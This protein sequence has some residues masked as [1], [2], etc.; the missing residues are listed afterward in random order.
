MSRQEESARAW[1]PYITC[2]ALGTEM[3]A[4]GREGVRAGWSKPSG[5]R[6]AFVPEQRVGRSNRVQAA[7]L[8]GRPDPL[9]HEAA[10]ATSESGFQIQCL[11]APGPAG[12]EKG[13]CSLASRFERCFCPDSSQVL[14]GCPYPSPWQLLDARGALEGRFR[15]VLSTPPEHPRSASDCKSTKTYLLLG[16]TRV[17]SAGLPALHLAEDGFGNSVPQPCFQWHP[18]GQ[19][20]GD[21]SSGLH[22]VSSR[23]PAGEAFVWPFRPAQRWVMLLCTV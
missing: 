18:V 23:W 21:P 15:P 17:S 2:T 5:L 10:G 8:R 7:A 16:V 1:P 11:R 14:W 13:T 19:G 20:K 6:G 12:G 4:R 9:A 3:D 22:S